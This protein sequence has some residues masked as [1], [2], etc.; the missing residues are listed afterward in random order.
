MR[1]YY[2][3]EHAYLCQLDDGGV[4]LDLR[5][6][7]YYGLSKLDMSSL[8]S[9]I[10]G[11]DLPGSNEPNAACLGEV[12]ATLRTSKL[13]TRDRQC[14]RPFSQLCIACTNA[15]P[16]EGRDTGE[17]QV[18]PIDLLRFLAAAVLAVTELRFV[19]LERIVLR[20]RKRK[21]GA[22]APHLQDAGLV[23]LVKIYRRL[24]PLL[25]STREFCLRDSLVL[26]EFLASYRV[27]PTWIIGV[28]TRPFGAHAW[29]QQGSTVLSDTLEHVET[30]TP[31]LAV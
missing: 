27:F 5:T 16:F 8:S 24:S 12:L 29:V 14:G 11:L 19:S 31:I 1:E 6:E 30:F 25:F 10:N 3:C 21:L 17:A 13:V 23:S 20:M 26:V 28:R 15:L 2:L 18:R 9:T 7:K 22:H 4:L